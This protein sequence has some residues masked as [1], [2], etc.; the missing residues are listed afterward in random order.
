M[1]ARR[2]AAGLSPDFVFAYTDPAHD[3]DVS[4]HM[5]QHGLVEGGISQVFVLFVLCCVLVVVVCVAG[6]CCVW[7]ALCVRQPSSRQRQRQT[8]L[9]KHTQTHTH[10]QPTTPP[11]QKKIFYSVLAAPCGD[12]SSGGLLAD[13]GANFGWFSIFAAKLGCR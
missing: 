3:V 10:N 2:T 4:A 1:R 6:L 13:V 11:R 12:P 8:T 9:E 5:A 7:R